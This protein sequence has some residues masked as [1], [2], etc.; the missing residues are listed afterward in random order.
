MVKLNKQQLL[1]KKIISLKEF[2]RFFESTVNTDVRL[3][4]TAP[5]VIL[6][7]KLLQKKETDKDHRIYFYFLKEKPMKPI[8]KASE[9]ASMEHLQ[10]LIQHSVNQFG[11]CCNKCPIRLSLNINMIYDKNHFPAFDSYLILKCNTKHVRIGR[12][13]VKTMQPFKF[14][15]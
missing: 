14:C 4:S 3:Q 5:C 15:W 11:Y 9:A 10:N 13:S 8:I 2:D 7:R 1:S 6:W 12:C